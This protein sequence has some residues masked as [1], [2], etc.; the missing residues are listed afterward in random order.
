M[1]I[2]NVFAIMK[3]RLEAVPTKTIDDLKTEVT[4]VRRGLPDTYLEEF[5]T[6]IRG[7]CLPKF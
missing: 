7:D 4:N 2:E 6:S 3:R 5:C 1:P